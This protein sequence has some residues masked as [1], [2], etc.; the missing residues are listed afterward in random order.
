[1]T[2]PFPPD[3]QPPSIPPA[4]QHT[5][6][7]ARTK[8]Q[9]TT[10]WL[11][12]VALVF[13]IVAIYCA[14]LAG[15]WASY[16]Q[17]MDASNVVLGEEI[18]RTRSDLSSAKVSLKTT[19]EQLTTAQ[20]RISELAREKAQ[21]GDDRENQR[22]R[23]EDTAQLATRAFEASDALG[24]CVAVQTDLVESLSDLTTAQSQLVVELAKSP[25]ARD[26]TLVTQENERVGELSTVVRDAQEKIE[27]TCTEAI[28][29]Y[30]TL[31][32]KLEES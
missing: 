3:E 5:V 9:R 7:T 18:S 20:K 29:D 22:I 30:N 27:Q 23:A 6:S 16:G 10:L 1:M 31:I 12:I 17:E 21:A 19:R 2:V 26:T 14:V 24:E 8:P 32:T 25:G 11:S 4:S 13:L 15:R 28:N